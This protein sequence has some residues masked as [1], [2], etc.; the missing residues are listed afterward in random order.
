MLTALRFCLKDMVHDLSRTL[1]SITGLA[2]VIASYFVLSALAEVF[3]NL[4]KTTT[5]SRNLI[6]IQGDMIDPSDAVVEPQVI[7]AARELIPETISRISPIIFRHI[8]VDEH[9]VQLRAA[10][11]QDWEPV[12]HLA[13][14][15]GTWPAGEG[16]IVVGEGIAQANSWEV[17][18]PVEIF[19]S[20][21][22][23]AGIFRA[24]GTAFASVWMPTQTF[25]AVFDTQHTYQAMF[26]QAAE[27]VDAETVRLKLQNDARLAN[28]YAVYFEDNYTQRNIQ[29]HIDLSSMMTV[30]SRIALLGI[31]FG[32]FNSTTLS[33]VERAR[34]LGILLGVGFSH[35]S[36]R[37]FILLRAM[38]LGGLAYGIGLAA[39]FL[40]ISFQQAAA[41][42][43]ILG[44]PFS[45]AITP[46]IAASGLLWVVGLAF[47]GAWLSV[48]NL[49][50]LQVVELVR[51]V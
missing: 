34:E 31:A 37:N 10:D 36:V 43:F 16:E 2:V 25:W 39:A 23:I 7:E 1:L 14:V 17:G 19:G 45:L 24:P 50:A 49:F 40:Y 5:V 32:I 47:L 27:G 33:T 29:S 26:V 51:A 13:L 15:Q 21:F 30:V 8:R 9:V 44:V 20:P 42:I 18:T 4:L 11:M 6:V 12:Y 3:T 35:R 41:P 28:H 48:R 38:L 22:R 46:G